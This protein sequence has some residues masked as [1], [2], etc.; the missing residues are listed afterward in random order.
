MLDRDSNLM[1]D[2]MTCVDEMKIAF[3]K[4]I[5]SIVIDRGERNVIVLLL[6]STKCTLVHRC[7][8]QVDVMDAV[9]DILVT[10]TLKRR[11]HLIKAIEND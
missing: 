11:C 7:I 6:S 1:I 2:L 3:H 8:Q 4:S 10:S 9:D 5:F